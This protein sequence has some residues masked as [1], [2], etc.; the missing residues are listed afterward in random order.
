MSLML[1]LMPKG[2]AFMSLDFFYPGEIK[3]VQLKMSAL[4][5]LSEGKVSSHITE[6]YFPERGCSIV[7]FLKRINLN[8]SFSLLYLKLFM[9]FSFFFLISTFFYFLIL[10]IMPLI[11]GGGKYI[12]SC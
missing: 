4:A 9:H 7:F 12:F 8:L 5:Y 6:N 1:K 11:L 3:I 2:R 10:Q